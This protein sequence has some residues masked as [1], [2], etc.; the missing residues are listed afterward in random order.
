MLVADLYELTMATAYLRY[1]M[2]RPA[3]FSLFA[4]RVPAGRGFLVATGVDEAVDRLLAL[5]VTDE[6]V[7][8]LATVLGCPAS[9]V[10]GLRGLRF[11]GDAEAVPE[12]TVVL[13][14]E[15]LLEVTA[16]LAEAQV[17][18]TTLLNAVTYQT[19]VASKA[20]R[21]TIAAAG[22]PV[23]D[24]SLRRTHGVEAGVAAARAC[25]VAGFTATSD[26][27]AAQRYGLR[28]TGT[29]A[30]SFVQAF[31]DETSAFDAF[32][33]TFPDAPTFLVDTYDTAGGVAAAVTVIRRRGLADRAAVRLD[34]GDLAAE[35][36]LARTL[37]DGE[38]LGGVRIVVSGGVDEVVIDEL[39]RTAAPVDVFAAGT[40]V[41]TAADAPFLD[42]AYKLVEYAG[43]PVTK[44][45]AGKGYP[46]GPKQVWRRSGAA[47]V[48]ARRDEHPPAGASPLLVP[49]VR[50]GRR[51][52][53][54]SSLVD[55]AAR[56]A[57]GVAALPPS[58]RRIAAPVAP[59][60]RLSP[61]LERLHHDVRR[62]LTAP[63]TYQ[64][65]SRA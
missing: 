63:G 18:E 32:A 56:C 58:A 55:A 34:S 16:P 54:P 43:R 13:A 3:T 9:R 50:G 2:A 60:C 52:R 29:M 21:C 61:G 41:G 51:V 23:V 6:D 62:R 45:S 27:A 40:R 49:V 33:E 5:E 24:F 59:S 57:A 7:E 42:S 31:P 26:V 65:R 20:A 38:G 17:A 25:A 14:D 8:W 35:A 15:P 22:R 37:L 11:N 46:P 12:G 28:A 1:G 19:S 47:D 36:R 53:A 4:R 48:L 44:L 39:V 30:H 64:E 10:A